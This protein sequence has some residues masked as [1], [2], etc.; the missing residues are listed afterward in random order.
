MYNLLISL[1]I[2]SVVFAAVALA[3]QPIAGVIPALLVFILLAVLTSRRTAKQVQADMEG[4]VPLLQNQKVD[5]ARALILGAREKYGKWQFLVR[6]QMDAQLGMIEYMRLNFDDAL[7]LLQK[8]RVRDWTAK[9]CVGAIHYRRKRYDAAW[10]AMKAASAMARKEPM[11]YVVWAVLLSRQGERSEA[12][13]VLAEGLGR[14]PESRVLKDL[15]K[16]IANKKRIDEGRLPEAW[17]QIFPEDMIR[18]MQARGRRGGPVMQGSP[19]RGQMTAPPPRACG[20]MAR[21]R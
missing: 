5:E 20:K 21:R 6:G 19:M 8:S 10:G 1:G 2:S 4:L 3:M 11:V 15:K 14:V 9:V 18:K 16:T 7:P 13:E 17:N 12:L